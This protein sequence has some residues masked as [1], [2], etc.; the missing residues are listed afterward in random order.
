MTRAEL[1]IVA[2]VL[3][4]AAFVAGMEWYGTRMVAR[5]NVYDVPMLYCQEDELVVS[6]WNYQTHGMHAYCEAMDDMP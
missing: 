5:E 4:V 2:I 3:F 6:F 1:T